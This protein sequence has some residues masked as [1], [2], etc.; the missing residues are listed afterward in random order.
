MIVRGMLVLVVFHH[1]I[2][3][4]IFI[5]FVMHLTRVVMSVREIFF[6]LHWSGRAH[7]IAC[8]FSRL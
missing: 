5:L 4:H 1:N 2:F 8:R 3:A 6:L 7:P